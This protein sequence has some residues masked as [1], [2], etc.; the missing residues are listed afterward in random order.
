MSSDDFSF[1]DNLMDFFPLDKV[2]WNAGTYDQYLADL[3]KTVVDNYECG[4]YQVAYFY[5][6]LIFMSYVYYCV[7]RAYQIHPNRMKDVF[8]PINAYHGKDD[9]P[10]LENYSSI[11]AFSKIPEKEIFKVFY[12][13]G[14]EDGL[15]QAISTYIKKRDNYAHATGK[16]N[17]SEDELIQN[18]HSIVGNMKCLSN[19]FIP[20]IKEKYIE[21]LL[22]HK[23][24]DFTAIADTASDFIL[25]NALSLNHIRF[26]CNM[27]LS[28]IRN[29]S[30]E[31]K[32]NYHLVKKIHC[33]F[34]EYCI[35]DKAIEEPETM[36]ALRDDAYLCY[37]Y[38]GNAVEYVE[39]ELGISR[40]RCGKDGVEFPVYECP[41]CEEEQLVFDAEKEQYHCFACDR[42]FTTKELSFC[43]RCGSLM[44]RKDDFQICQMCIAN[45]ERE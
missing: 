11:Y 33:A 32:M 36:Q 15:I 43:E 2:D 5:A 8:Y 37:R 21:Y 28:N 10:K 7:E 25:D 4:N 16:G 44:Q 9:K 39:N 34:I 20:I 29:D 17:I 3:R 40:Y 35:E 1:I 12:I 27:G 23:L 19:L 31:F 30:E 38:K 14:M 41:E 24:N 13:M 18:I 22:E 6:H 45:I 42:N 26:I